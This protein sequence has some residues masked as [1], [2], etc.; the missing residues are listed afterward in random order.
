MRR[1]NDEMQMEI[2]FILDEETTGVYDIKTFDVHFPMKVMT[3]QLDDGL[4]N[5]KLTVKYYLD[6]NF[7]SQGLFEV[8]ISFKEE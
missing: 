1:E 2:E 4:A 7:E 8:N 3:D 6:I 5:G